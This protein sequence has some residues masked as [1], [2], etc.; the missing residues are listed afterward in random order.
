M[1]QER[2]D[3]KMKNYWIEFNKARN[4]YRVAGKSRIKGCIEEVYKR[5]KYGMIETWDTYKEAEAGLDEF[6]E[7]EN[8]D[9]ALDDWV[10]V[11]EEQ[12]KDKS[13]EKKE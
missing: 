5:S 12:K 8:W 6:I 10:A 13:D 9:N 4:G 11:T 2:N 3:I 1:E 7:Q